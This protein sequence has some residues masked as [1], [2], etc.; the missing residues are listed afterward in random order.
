MF[1][2]LQKNAT[3]CSVFSRCVLGQ[4]SFRCVQ[5]FCIAQVN[6]VVI[7]TQTFMLQNSVT[8]THTHTHTHTD[9]HRHT[10]RDIDTHTET[11]T[12][13]DTDTHTDTSH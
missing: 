8:H 10:H 12:E 13:T 1:Q 5:P 3:I 11:D 6:K 9:T 4:V 2:T 7:Y